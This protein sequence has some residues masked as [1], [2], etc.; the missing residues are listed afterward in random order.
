MIK[1]TQLVDDNRA[2]FVFEVE[3]LKNHTYTVWF[4]KNYYKKLTEGK[5]NADELVKKSFEFLSER[6]PASSILPE[7]ELPLIGQYFP[8]Y[9]D[10]I[11]KRQRSVG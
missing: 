7:F 3:I 5:I 10:T 1:V 2:D 9:E 8:E 4:S 11:R 6:E